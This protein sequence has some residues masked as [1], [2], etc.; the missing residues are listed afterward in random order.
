MSA[1]R[2]AGWRS[3]HWATPGHRAGNPR[4]GSSA[5]RGRGGRTRAQRRTAPSARRHGRHAASVRDE[6][7]RSVARVS[8]PRARRGDWLM[9]PL[10]PA[11]ERGRARSVLR[12]GAGPRLTPVGAQSV[13]APLVRRRGGTITS[14]AAYHVARRHPG[15]VS[16]VVPAAA[17]RVLRSSPRDPVRG[18]RGGPRSGRAGRRRIGPGAPRQTTRA[19]G[20]LRASHG[21][22]SGNNC[23]GGEY[24]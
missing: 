14:G 22:R 11:S 1:C 23:V 10:R 5:R 4:P 2:C 13:L 9:R 6:T 17:A 15:H 20:R 19:R 7:R 8:R 12:R 24:R 18:I 21:A 16:V 3:R